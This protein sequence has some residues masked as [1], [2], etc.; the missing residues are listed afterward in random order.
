MNHVRF[1]R[2][3]VVPLAIGLVA[4]AL[5]IVYAL[6]DARRAL[7]AFIAA[8]G[9]AVATVLAAMALV[10]VLHLTG[11][12]WW[13]VLRR[14]FVATAGTAPIFVLLFVP[15]GAA[16]T[17]V[18]PWESPPADLSRHIEDVL[19]HRR[20]WNQPAFFLARSAFY[21]T[22]WTVLAVLL[23]RA[24]REHARE[25]SSPEIVG[26]ERTISAVGLP[27]LAFT[28]TF[29][30]FDWL[31]SLQPGWTSNIFGLYVFTSG[32]VSA[33][34]VLAVGSW[35]AARSELVPGGIGPDHVHAV[36]RLML[37]A[38]ILWAYIGFFQLLL[39]WI[40]NLPS[41]ASFY[42]MRAH[43]SWAVVDVVLFVGRFVLPFF[44]LLSRPL[45]RSP[46][47]LAVVGVW[48][49]LMSM[50]DFAWLAI[51]ALR[52]ELAL[53][54]VLPFFAIGG[55]VWAYGA[56]LV[57]LR[58]RRAAGRDLVALDPALRDAL[59]YRSP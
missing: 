17:I 34:A 2:G 6:H 48:L 26:T 24:D 15:I 35:L 31:M 44:V 39:V 28:L 13:L 46:S 16:F 7:L 45:K 21:L 30:A 25:P 54:D 32:L 58:S 37:M 19:E 14:V 3:V 10:M 33:M 9:F 36:G 53:A 57:A 23:R 22:S 12:R 43:G 20:F 52:A 18:Y 47:R 4:S 38:V 11:A 41:E 59:R 1:G 27:V 51:P 50:L 55:L 8:Y 56:H 49:V 42:A 5:T 29:A 40:A